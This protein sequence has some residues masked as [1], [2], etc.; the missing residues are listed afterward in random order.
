MHHRRGPEIGV[1]VRYMFITE[2]LSILRQMKT[3]VLALRLD[4]YM[5]GYAHVVCRRVAPGCVL[6]E[7][8]K[9]FISWATCS[10]SA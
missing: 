7:D 2:V 1:D 10:F 5:F 3:G 4:L 9:I 8:V 6:V